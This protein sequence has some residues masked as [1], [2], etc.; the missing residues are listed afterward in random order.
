[1]TWRFWVP[2]P[3]PAQNEMI[4]KAKGFG[5]RGIGY[6]QMKA[7]WTDTIAWIAKAAHIP[8]LERIRLDFDWVS[9]DKRHDPDN[10]EAGQKFVWD[11]LKLAGV[12][13]NDGWAQNAGSS[14]HHR[15]VCKGEKPGVWVTVEQAQS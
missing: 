6:S 14:H 4:S 12:I 8:K 7:S 11:A 5:G 3:L 2:G 1:V 15:L 9:K 13:A 10:I